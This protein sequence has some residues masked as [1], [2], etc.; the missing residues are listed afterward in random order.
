MRLIVGLGNPGRK[1]AATRHNI[2]VRV[3]KALAQRCKLSFKEKIG[4]SLC[5]RGK[6]AEEE[7]LLALPQLFMN[8]SGKAVFSLIEEFQLKPQDILV[9]CDDVDLEVGRLRIRPSG[10]SG[11]HRGLLS[12]IDS[13]KTEEFARLRVGIGR[14]KDKDTD[15]AD[16]VLGTFT[17]HEKAK[18]KE[19]LKL[20]VDC[21]LLWLK[22]G[23]A[24]AMNKYNKRSEYL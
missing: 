3:V 21:C 9:V 6:I 4:F 15:L 16:Y 23:V 13:L 12:I 19:A 8:L 14:P 17:A 18:V 24:E 5:A 20:A 1:Y 11:G 7:F 10:S 22:K 2:G